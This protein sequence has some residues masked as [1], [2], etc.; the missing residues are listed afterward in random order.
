MPNEASD[1]L[2]YEQAL[3]DQ[4][5]EKSNADI[6][7]ELQSNQGMYYCFRSGE[8]INAVFTAI[9]LCKGEPVL[10]G[11]SGAIAVGFEVGCRACK[12]AMHMSH[13][14]LLRRSRQEG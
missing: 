6:E 11:M 9:A 2:A 4:F 5:A 10:A 13:D 1:Y 3:A 12:A 7:A 8:V 14:E